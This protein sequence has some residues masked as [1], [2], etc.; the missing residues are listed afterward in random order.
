MFTRTT[1]E[2]AR[3][4]LYSEFW[5]TFT[6]WDSGNVEFWMDDD[7]RVAAYVRYDDNDTN[8]IAF[9]ETRERGQGHGSQIIRELQTEKPSLYISGDIDNADCARFWQRMGFDLT[10]ATLVDGSVVR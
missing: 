2:D 9:F 5:M 6:A 7:D 3:D 1:S 4:S 8:G 10:G